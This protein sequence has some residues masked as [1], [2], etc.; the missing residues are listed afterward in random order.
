MEIKLHFKDTGVPLYILPPSRMYG[1]MKLNEIVDDAKGVIDI[2]KQTKE[3]V[4][5]LEKKNILRVTR[6]NSYRHTHGGK[7]MGTFKFACTNKMLKR[8]RKQAISYG[9]TVLFFVSFVLLL[10]TM[11]R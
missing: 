10:L 11:I 6:I 7:D 5:F 9:N 4:Y 8:E 1:L 2:Y 3:S